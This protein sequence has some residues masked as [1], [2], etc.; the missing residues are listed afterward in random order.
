MEGWEVREDGGGRMVQGGGEAWRHRST[1]RVRTRGQTGWGQAAT[2]PLLR[3][4]WGPSPGARRQELKKPSTTSN[5]V[6]W[7][8]WVGSCQEEEGKRA[9]LGPTT[10]L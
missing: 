5:M 7:G 4:Q 3:S 2:K 8:P 10:S 1:Y 9:G 6:S